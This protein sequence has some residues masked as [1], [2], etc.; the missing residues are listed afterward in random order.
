[1]KTMKSWRYLI[2]GVTT[3]T[4][5]SIGSMSLAEVNTVNAD[6]K[7]QHHGQRHVDGAYPDKKHFRK[8]NHGLALTT[9]QKQQLAEQRDLQ[10]PEIQQQ[11]IAVAEA[12]LALRSAIEANADEA[13][14]QHLADELGSLLAQQTL[15]RAKQHQLFLSVLTPEQQEMLAQLKQERKGKWRG[16]RRHTEA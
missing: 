14:L 9:E 10:K 5:M 1:M 2:T 11:R 4:L 6:C 7:S 13:Q 3:L 16:H 12:R 8:M 15:A